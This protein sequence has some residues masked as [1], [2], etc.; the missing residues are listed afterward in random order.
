MCCVCVRVRVRVKL[1]VSK[2]PGGGDPQEDTTV[3]KSLEE[4]DVYDSGFMGE[5]DRLLAGTNWATSDVEA[6]RAKMQRK[7][8]RAQERVARANTRQAELRKLVKD[9]IKDLQAPQLRWCYEPRKSNPKLG[10]LGGV[11]HTIVVR[12]SLSSGSLEG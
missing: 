9:M 10:W 7:S 11:T 2:S 5:V 4:L 1:K 3:V 12:R 8:E 6:V